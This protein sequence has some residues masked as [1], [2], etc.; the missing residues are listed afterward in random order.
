MIS[1]NKGEVMHELRKRLP[2]S[3]TCRLIV[4]TDKRAQQVVVHLYEHNNFGGLGPNAHTGCRILPTRK[5]SAPSR[6]ST[7]WGTWW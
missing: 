5:K 4:D 6:G 2:K 7:I 1:F 3:V